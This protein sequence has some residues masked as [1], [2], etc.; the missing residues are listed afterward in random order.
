MLDL[1]SLTSGKIL[2]L[3]ASETIETAAPVSN[4]IVNGF[5]STS[6]VTGALSLNIKYSLDS[7]SEESCCTKLVR[8]RRCCIYCRHRSADWG[9]VALLPTSGILEF[10]V[11][12]CMVGLPTS[13]ICS[14]IAVRSSVNEV[15]TVP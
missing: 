6:I 7:E 1:R 9:N 10:A 3:V 13:H 12:S 15:D 4:F 14:R 8:W 2:L 5:P 11:V